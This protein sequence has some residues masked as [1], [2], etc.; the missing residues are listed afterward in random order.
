MHTHARTH[1]PPLPQ[2]VAANRCLDALGRTQ[3]YRL[4]DMTA[5]SRVQLITFGLFAP[6]HAGGPDG[7]AGGAGG[8]YSDV[9]GDVVWA[10]TSVRTMP[11]ARFLP[12]LTTLRAQ[13]RRCGVWGLGFGLGF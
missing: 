6:R 2:I 11:L 1:V 4:A 12:A 3:R 5:A 10:P 9:G 13:V 8:G 7:S